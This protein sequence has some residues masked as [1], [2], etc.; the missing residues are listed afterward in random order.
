M[1]ILVNDPL[2]GEA[3]SLSLSED[4][5]LLPSGEAVLQILQP[6]KQYEE[7]VLKC[8]HPSRHHL[9]VGG[10]LV[11]IMSEFLCVLSYVLVS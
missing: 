11:S 8:V 5:S 3:L 7:K 10:E 6:Y 2:T 1:H 4:F 9:C